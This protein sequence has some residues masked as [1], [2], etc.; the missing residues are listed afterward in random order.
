[1]EDDLARRRISILEEPLLVFFRA[2]HA[3][4]RPGNGL[5]ALLLKFLFALA[6]CPICSGLDASQGIVNQRQQRPVH[7]RLPEEKFLGVRVRSLVRKVH[8]RI[9]IREARMTFTRSAQ[10][11]TGSSTPR[12]L[13][14]SVIPESVD[15]ARAAARVGWRLAGTSG[16]FERD[17]HNAA[18]TWFESPRALL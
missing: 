4:A 1:M 3:M 9:V 8:R 7:I 15:R 14:M 17:N 2:S 13:S 6:A 10:G 18:G 12:V 11:A 16:S 5:Q